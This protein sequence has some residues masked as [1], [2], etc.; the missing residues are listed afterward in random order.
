MLVTNSLEKKPAGGRELLCK[1][2]Y[3]VL[4][5]IYGERLVLFE[6][7]RIPVQGG[8]ALISAFVGHIDGLTDD[9]IDKAIN[10]IEAEDVD[11]IFVD[12]SNLGGFI[13]VVKQRLPDVQVTTFF[14]NVEA[15]FFLGS[16]RQTK[17]LRALAVLVANYLAE[18]KAVCYS[19]KII[20]LSQRDSR[21][22]KKIYGR[23]AT[24]I[25]PMALEDKAL[26]RVSEVLDT[27]KE[28][29][30]LF[31]GG[32]FYANR[33]GIN[34]FVEHVVPH[35]DMKICIVGRGLDD[36]KPQLVCDKKVVVVGAVESLS[37]WYSNAQFVIAPIFDGSGMK[38]KVAEALMYGKRVYGTSEAF[39]G[40]DEVVAQVG[41]I[42]NTAEA[43]IEAINSENAD[44]FCHFDSNLRAIYEVKYSHSAAI[45]RFKNIMMV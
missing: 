24:H 36:L 37:D 15:R 7:S 18:R 2:N 28:K 13:K 38:T 45:S 11:K 35:I 29:Y 27:S 17:T 9:I 25:S 8:R 4:R 30:A 42:C 20:C 5:Q 44:S 40:Y 19:D 3:D 16:L 14:H 23:G 43:F 10:K 22:L 12:G 39:V 33:E 1:L 41:E 34:W 26:P 31:V 21:L 32:G 6:L